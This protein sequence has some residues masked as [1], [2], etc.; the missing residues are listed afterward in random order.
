MK[1]VMVLLFV[2]SLLMSMPLLA[3]A[4]GGPGT[5]YAMTNAA[6]GNA[7]VVY[8][9]A[10]NGQLTLVDTF[11]TYGLGSGDALASNSLILSPDNRWLFAVNAGSNDISFFKVDQDHLTLL[12]V[13]FFPGDSPVVSLT[14]HQNLLFVLHAG[15]AGNI[16][17]YKV[18]ADGRLTLIDEIDGNA[19]DLAITPNG[20]YLYTV[21]AGDG[22]VGMFKIDQKNGNLIDLGEIGGLPVDGNAVGI[23]AR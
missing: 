20:Q 5:V 10:A 9:R 6:A 3:Q 7:I 4:K 21:N 13:V 15:E 8:H 11:P 17:W 12:Q 23:A 16:S 1:R 18:V 2:L 14:I 22:S 19:V